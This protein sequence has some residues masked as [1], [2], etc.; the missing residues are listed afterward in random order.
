MKNKNTVNKAG[1]DSNAG[2]INLIGNGSVIEGT[3]NS[4]GDLRI[5]GIVKGSVS[6]KS[7]VVV[8]STGKVEGDIICQ[9][10]DISGQ[11]KGKT[12]VAETL[13]LKSTA[14]INGDIITSKLIVEV[15]AAFTGSCNMGP[16]I[17]D[18]KRGESNEVNIEKQNTELK[19]KTA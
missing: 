15:G 18:L 6:S 5:D 14:R 19:E 17:K 16:M 1:S 3:I 7:K 10:A 12:T 9:N 4:S 2:S 11:V 13:F 8:G